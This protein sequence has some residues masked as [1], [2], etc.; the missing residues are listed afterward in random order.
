[1]FYP[2]E[3]MNQT[4]SAGAS[5]LNDSINE[6]HTNQCFDEKAFLQIEVNNEINVSTLVA[7]VVVVVTFFTLGILN[8]R[9]EVKKGEVLFVCSLR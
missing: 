6:E 1:M 2:T 9:C 7:L 4:N 3:N 8:L 5:Q